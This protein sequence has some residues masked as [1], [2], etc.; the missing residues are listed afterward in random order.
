MQVIELSNHP[1]D[2]LADVSRRR[3]AAQSRT[4][5][6]SGT[7]SSSTRPACRR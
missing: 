7:R 1:G 4:Q 6:K 5:D 2:M 3:H